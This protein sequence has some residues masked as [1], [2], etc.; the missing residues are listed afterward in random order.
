MRTTLETLICKLHSKERAHIP[1]A[2]SAD[3]CH[4]AAISL[5]S[6][7]LTNSGARNKREQFDS[8]EKSIA[9]NRSRLVSKSFPPSSKERP[10]SPVRHQGIHPRLEIERN[11]RVIQENGRE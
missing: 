7:G 5:P 2:I 8:Q 10:A 11:E 3:R 9:D 6:L 4:H 1:M